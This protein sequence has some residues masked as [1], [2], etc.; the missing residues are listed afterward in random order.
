MPP[1]RFLL[2]CDGYAIALIC[3]WHAFCGESLLRPSCL[4]NHH[5]I[6]LVNLQRAS[7]LV[8]MIRYTIDYVTAK[9]NPAFIEFVHWW[10][11][12]CIIR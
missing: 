4:S 9:V 10:T 5:T 7:M 6:A 2:T 1:P 3:P 12:N 11:L 8:L